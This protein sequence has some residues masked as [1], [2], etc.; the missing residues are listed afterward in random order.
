M[1]LFGTE[2]EYGIAVEGKG[3]G[4][5]VSEAR[6]V[7]RAYRGKSAS[8]WYYRGEDPR[9]DMRGFH[10]DRLSQD[11]DDAQFDAPGQKLLPV[12]EER[13][14]RVLVNGARLYND[15][16]HPEYATPECNSLLSL[17]THDKAGERIVWEATQARMEQRA[18]GRVQIFKNNTDFHGS[19]YGT[20]ENYL[21]RREAPFGELSSGLLPFF[22]TRIIYAGAGKMGIEPN[23]DAG[24]YQISQR[25][26]FFAVEASVDTLHRRPIVN[27]RDEPHAN[28]L[29]WRRLHVICGDANMSEYATALKIGATYLVTL[30]LE[31]GWKPS[32]KLKD[33]VQA[34]KDVSRDQ[35]Y[36][37]L[38]DAGTQGKMPAVDVQR[39]YLAAAKVRLAGRGADT[40]WVLK[41]WEATLD[42]LDSNPLL[43]GDRLDW[44]AKRSLLADYVESEGCEWSDEALSSYDLAYS[45][46]DPEEGLYHALEQAGE[47]V[48]LTTDEAI[49]SAKTQAPVGTRAAIR[50][51]IVE[52]FA[53]NIGAIG[54]NKA[55]LRT[56]KESWL[57]D[58]DE[59]LTPETV[60]PVVAR[61][62]T[63]ATVED[64]LRAFPGS[65]K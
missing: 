22:A 33:P 55:I 56:E 44:V 25:A 5:L 35:S 13:A 60:A 41:E 21:M 4:D 34:I 51:T 20:H 36:C 6:A 53:E 26:D 17:V 42:G 50:G 18:V 3:A 39:A 12:E 10:V 31:Q 32:I 16:G 62:E 2:T 30:L 15:H 7:V 38:V 45:N 54:W 49:E 19:S 65:R 28:A 9:N 29:N 63:A 24:V 59:Y 47:M 48:R 64:L 52:K 58:L 23:G 46:I 8:P 57:A 61:L 40:D 27:T 11:P 43:L 14:D 37:W 1:P